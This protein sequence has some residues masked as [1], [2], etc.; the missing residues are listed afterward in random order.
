MSNLQ[1]FG[2]V[3]LVLESFNE[4]FKFIHF[5]IQIGV[6]FA[7]PGYLFLNIGYPYISVFGVFKD[8]LAE[9]KGNQSVSHPTCRNKRRAGEVPLNGEGDR[10]HTDEK[11][12]HSTLNP[13]LL[14][15]VLNITNPLMIFATGLDCFRL[16]FGNPTSNY[17]PRD[18]MESYYKTGQIAD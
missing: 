12:V 2:Q 7:I 5:L 4:C 10:R 3:D 13:S 14:N 16:N 17:M 15:S 8:N 11:L 9:G 6:L 18:W 1:R